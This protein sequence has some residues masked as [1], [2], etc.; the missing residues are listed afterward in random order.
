MC[1]WGSLGFYNWSSGCIHSLH[2]FLVRMNP[3]YVSLR[4]EI[5]GVALIYT[6]GR[7]ITKVYLNDV[8]NESYVDC[9]ALIEVALAAYI[10]FSV[11]L[12]VH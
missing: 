12:N 8:I 9:D 4:I 2:R 1:S 6:K 11:C 3:V 10:M 7:L 5:E